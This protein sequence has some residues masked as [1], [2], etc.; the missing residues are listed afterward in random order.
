MRDTCLTSDKKGK[1]LHTHTHT[2]A[3]MLIHWPV[4][5]WQ[6]PINQFVRFRYDCT[7]ET[8]IILHLGSNRRE[9]NCY[10]GTMQRIWFC[11]LAMIEQITPFNRLHHT[12]NR[13]HIY[14]WQHQCTC[15]DSTSIETRKTHRIKRFF[16]HSRENTRRTHIQVLSQ[17]SNVAEECL[18]RA[19][20]HNIRFQLAS[21]P[22]YLYRFDS[23]YWWAF[24]I[25][26]SATTTKTVQKDYYHKY[27]RSSALV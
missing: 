14:K 20:L 15:K 2:L 7:M 17:Y 13:H 26:S 11:K 9:Y 1:K 5:R 19:R 10:M 3:I 8:S 6:R 24:L 22:K 25:L 4:F 23:C 16:S 12:A 21:P 27:N 18:H